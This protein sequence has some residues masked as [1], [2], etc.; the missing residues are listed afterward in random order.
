MIFRKNKRAAAAKTG[1]PAPELLRQARELAA[2]GKPEA[3][4]DACT[5]CLEADPANVDAHILALQL[6]REVPA[7]GLTPEEYSEPYNGEALQKAYAAR[8][9]VLQGAG[10]PAEA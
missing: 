5:Q 9:Q 8:I 7:L 4:L 6:I 3:A 2:A 10:R 1:I